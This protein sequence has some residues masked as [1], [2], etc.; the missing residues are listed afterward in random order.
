MEFTRTDVVLGVFILIIIILEYQFQMITMSNELEPII[1]LTIF[2]FF[3]IWL[4]ILAYNVVI[5]TL[6]YAYPDTTSLASKIKRRRLVRTII[7]T[8]SILLLFL[9]TISSVWFFPFSIILSFHLLALRAA[10]LLLGPEENPFKRPRM[11]YE[12]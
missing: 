9:G 7:L 6:D 3:L 1:Y 11:Y 8:C 5:V 12:G 2:V 4:V 10:F